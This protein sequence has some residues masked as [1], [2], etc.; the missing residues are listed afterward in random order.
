MIDLK[1]ADYLLIRALRRATSSRSPT[2]G[3]PAPITPIQRRPRRRPRRRIRPPRTTSTS[4]LPP[5]VALPGSTQ[6][7]PPRLER[8]PTKWQ[9]RWNSSHA[10]R[11]LLQRR[12]RLSRAHHPR[13]LPGHPRNRGTPRDLETQ[14][15]EAVGLRDKQQQH[16]RQRRELRTD[17]K[18]YAAIALEKNMRLAA[19]RLAERKLD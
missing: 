10:H 18:R 14:G 11:L 19:E 16:N 4:T 7:C 15:D 9:L 1:R 17:R 3:P 6:S 5:E 13:R 2:S 8:P 12:P